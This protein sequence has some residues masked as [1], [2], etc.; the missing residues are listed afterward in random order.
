MVRLDKDE[1]KSLQSYLASCFRLWTRNRLCN[2]GHSNVYHLP[3]HT[4]SLHLYSNPAAHL[5]TLFFPDCIYDFEINV[6]NNERELCTA[7]PSERFSMVMVIMSIQINSKCLRQAFTRLVL[8]DKGCSLCKPQQTVWLYS[9]LLRSKRKLTNSQKTT[10][11]KG[12][13]AVT[14]HWHARVISPQRRNC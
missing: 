3:T 14:K 11:M 1:Y 5:N 6:M 10:G 8:Q 2:A 13:G 9:L 4:I 7:L 12:L